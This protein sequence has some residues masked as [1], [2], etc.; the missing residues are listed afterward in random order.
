MQTWA[1]NFQR[2]WCVRIG[3]TAAEEKVAS[4]TCD[5]EEEEEE[6]NPMWWYEVFVYNVSRTRVSMDRGYLPCI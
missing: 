1:G 5:K 4:T 2:S 3:D 6:S